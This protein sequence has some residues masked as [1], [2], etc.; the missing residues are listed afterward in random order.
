MPWPTVPPKAY[1]SRVHSS[2]ALLLLQSSFAFSR[3][4][5]FNIEA[6]PTWGFVPLRDFTS[7]RP[8]CE[9]SI[10]PRLRPQ[11]FSASRRL[12]P[13]TGSQA[14]FI[15]L[16]RSGFIPFRG[17]SPSCSRLPLFEGPLPP[18]RSTNARSP[19]EIG[20]HTRA[21][22]LRGLDP[23]EDALRPLGVNRPVARSPHQVHV[24]SRFSPSLTGVANLLG[25]FHL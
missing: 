13:P 23:H 1:A 7:R 18:C 19:T 10:S 11:A 4:M 20:C 5:S 25:G 24:S 2:W 8:I 14:C 12:S 22:R 9:A 21:S 3:P 17:F 16:P 6:L 15:P